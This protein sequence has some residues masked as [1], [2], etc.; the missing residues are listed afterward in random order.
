MIR[1]KQNYN[2]YKLGPTFQ[3]AKKTPIAVAV[4]QAVNLSAR[5][6]F[7]QRKRFVTCLVTIA[8]LRV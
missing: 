8:T 4:R 2:W 1:L 7:S 6:A 5:S 3:Y